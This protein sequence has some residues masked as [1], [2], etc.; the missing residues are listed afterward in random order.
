MKHILLFCCI[1]ALSL[2]VSTLVKAESLIA[3]WS[4]KDTPAMTIE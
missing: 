4:L 1:A 2:I 3:T